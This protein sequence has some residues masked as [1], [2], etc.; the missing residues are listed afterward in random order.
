MI[1]RGSRNR[2]QAA[3]TALPLA[4]SLLTAGGLAAACSSPGSSASGS[5]ASG[6]ASASSSEGTGSASTASLSS[7][8]LHIGDQAGSGSQ[9]LL[10]AAGLIS[11]LPFKV[12]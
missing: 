11:K 12:V 2:P 4:L 9:A 7:V 5:S 6:G 10:T 8:T 1:I 3:R